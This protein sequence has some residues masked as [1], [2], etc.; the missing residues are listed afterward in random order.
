MH[1]DKIHDNDWVAPVALF[2]GA[3]WYFIS[4]VYDDIA[5]REREQRLRDRE[6][7]SL[8]WDTDGNATGTSRPAS[9]SNQHLYPGLRERTPLK[10]KRINSDTNKCWVIRPDNEKDK[11]KGK[12]PPLPSQTEKDKEQ[13]TEEGLVEEIFIDKECPIC[14]DCFEADEV[15]RALSCKHT[16]H[17]RCIGKWF[18]KSSRCPIC[19]EPQTRFG[20]LVHA[21]F[22]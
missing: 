7:A 12:E 6:M 17:R 22:E 14:F 5:T 3:L 2:T 16:F 15:V 10:L 8:R 11:G 20:Q 4:L 18:V 13:E 21:L 9:P 1:Y 19:R